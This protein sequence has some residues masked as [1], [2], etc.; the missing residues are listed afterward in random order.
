MT[1]T[2]KDY[3]IN[4]KE[5]YTKLKLK[6]KPYVIRYNRSTSKANKKKLYKIIMD[7]EQQ[8]FDLELQR[9]N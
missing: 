7:Y 6:Q 5:Q 1:A 3:I 9:R 4:Y 2:V 8:L